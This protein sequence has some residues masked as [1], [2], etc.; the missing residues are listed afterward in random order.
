MF[1]SNNISYILTIL[2]AIEK[3]FYYTKGFKDEE[4]FFYANKQL[5]FNATANLLIAI[6][7]ENK[8][9]D[10][11]LK[12]SSKINWRN[13]S[14]M[15]D[16]ISHNYRGIDESMVW[17]IVQNYLGVLKVL[18]VEMLPKID[19]HTTYIREA[20]KSKYYEDLLYLEDLLSD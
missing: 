2:E 19:N 18:L 14:A 7:E 1:S 16:K 4:E 6:G 11:G 5:N 20:L 12:T 13:I 3:V 9:I 10:D 17:D 8:K 15:R